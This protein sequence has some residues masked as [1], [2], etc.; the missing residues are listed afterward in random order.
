MVDN[1]E[2]VLNQLSNPSL[3]I[4]LLLT[5]MLK[6]LLRISFRRKKI[7]MRGSLQELK[8]QKNEGQSLAENVCKS[9]MSLKNSN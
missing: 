1:R 8:M 7:T 5:F 2:Y 4:L 3:K 6:D 9:H